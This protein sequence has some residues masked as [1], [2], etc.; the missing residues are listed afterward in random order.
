MIRTLLLAFSVFFFSGSVSADTLP[1]SVLD[2]TFSKV[3]EEVG[4][5][6][7]LLRAICWAESHHQPDAYNHGDGVGTNHAFGMCQVLHATAREFGFKDPNCYRDFRASKT[8]TYNDCKLFGVYTSIYYGARY[9]K[10]KL[11]QYGGDWDDAI[12]AYNAGSVRICKTGYVRRAKDGSI[13]AR[14]VIGKLLNQ[15]YLNKVKRALKENR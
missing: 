10:E 6:E 5:P 3:A 1:S 7:K 11:D 14:C 15:N 4:V 13:I 12:A 2:E 9:L 8:R